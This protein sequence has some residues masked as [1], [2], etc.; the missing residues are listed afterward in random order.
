MSSWSLTN[1]TTTTSRTR[2]ATEPSFTRLQAIVDSTSISKP[3]AHPS[4]R[5]VRTVE[6]RRKRLRNGKGQPQATDPFDHH[7][8]LLATLT[9]IATRKTWTSQ[10][11]RVTYCWMRCYPLE[12]LVWLALLSPTFIWPSLT[13]RPFPFT[14]PLIVTRSRRS[15]G[16]PPGVQ[17]LYKNIV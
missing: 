11:Q 6:N 8:V 10:G 9:V 16:G 1:L 4:L 5:C 14:P 2:R 15:S 17:H 7:Q 3:S 13:P 12:S